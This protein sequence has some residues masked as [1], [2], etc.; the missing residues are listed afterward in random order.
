MEPPINKVRPLPSSPSLSHR[1]LSSTSQSINISLD[2]GAG[3]GSFEPHAHSGAH[4]QAQPHYLQHLHS[5]PI[6]A[7]RNTGHF[8]AQ[9]L[10]SSS[11]VEMIPLP[12]HGACHSLAIDT[13]TLSS[14]S[15]LSP[16]PS[17]DFYESN[18]PMSLASKRMSEDQIRAIRSSKKVREFYREQN[19]LITD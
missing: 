11:S 2:Y 17:P 9:T 15:L 10:V 5:A 3:V 1:A 8:S 13:A 19:D 18:D 12:H 4:L 16:E 14:S 6:P 7:T